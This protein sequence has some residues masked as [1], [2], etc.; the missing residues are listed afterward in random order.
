MPM[1]E[2]LAASNTGAAL[3][4]CVRSTYFTNSSNRKQKSQSQFSVLILS[5]LHWGCHDIS[6]PCLTSIFHRGIRVTMNT[7]QGGF[8]PWENASLVLS[9][10]AST[11]PY[12]LVL[13][14]SKVDAKR[15]VY[16]VTGVCRSTSFPAGIMVQSWC[17]VVRPSR[18]AFDPSIV[19]MCCTVLVGSGI[20][21]VSGTWGEWCC[22]G[23]WYGGD[24]E[25]V[26]SCILWC[27]SSKC[28]RQ[29][30]RKVKREKKDLLSPGEEKSVTRILVSQASPST[31]DGPHLVIVKFQSTVPRLCKGKGEQKRPNQNITIDPPSSDPGHVCPWSSCLGLV[32]I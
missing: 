23:R 5:T 22:E 7:S 11:S 6:N 15:C 30:K 18:C 12:L 16:M 27:G 26:V 8:D 25:V 4:P 2:F 31:E 10:K 24:D 21:R 32:A 14:F 17:R 3:I 1:N 19:I 20:V 9:Q 28:E 29:R 13:L